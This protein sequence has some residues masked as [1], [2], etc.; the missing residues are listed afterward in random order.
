MQGNPN[1]ANVVT[2]MIGIRNSDKDTNPFGVDDDGLECATIW[3][4]ELRLSEFNE[5]GWAARHNAGY[6]ERF[7]QL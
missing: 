4:N 1:L 3:A 5:G 6:A 2:V 7:G